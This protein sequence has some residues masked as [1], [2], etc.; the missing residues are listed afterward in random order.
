MVYLQPTNDSYVF[1]KVLS[2]IN[3]SNHI[4]AHKFKIMN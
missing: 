4:I 1:F 2:I 3:I